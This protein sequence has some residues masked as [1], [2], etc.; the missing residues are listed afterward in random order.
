MLT[1]EAK[2]TDAASPEIVV[3]PLPAPDY[4]PRAREDHPRS[5]ETAMAVR[6]WSWQA[7]RSLGLA[8]L[9]GL[10]GCGKSGE[11]GQAENAAPPAAIPGPGPAPADTAAL[12]APDPLAPPPG[13]AA[14]AA[15][16]RYDVSFAEATAQAFEGAGQPPV[17]TI[18][19]QPTAKIQA[20]VREVWPTIKLTD[21]AGNPTP[22]VV[23]L[24]TDAGPVEITLFPDVAPSHVRNFLALAQV[25]YYNGLTFERVIRL[26]YEGDD[27]M[28]R[29]LEVLTAGCPAGDGDGTHGHLGY[30][31]KREPRSIAHEEG[32]IGFVREEAPDSACCRLY[33]CL[34]PTPA[35]M[36][37]ELTAFGKV[38]SGLDVLKGIAARP[39]KPTETPSETHQFQ[40]PVKIKSVTRK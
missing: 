12:P 9:I 15:P 28:K 2:R 32:V 27:K 25:G 20:A 30:F 13:Q 7:L 11:P 38:T 10:A 22:I 6:Y 19:G 40:Q 39:V 36:E 37:V 4:G 31:L 1:S 18:A 26:D 21:A 35:G 24:D 8:A 14:A 34:T 3:D 17:T 5:E 16:V 33:F 23:V 29:R